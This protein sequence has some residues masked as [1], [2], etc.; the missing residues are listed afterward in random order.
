M[1]LFASSLSS[2]FCQRRR[3][4]FFFIIYSIIDSDTTIGAGSVVGRT[5]SAD[6]QITVVGS[7]LNIMPG[8]DIPGGTMVN[9]AWLQ[10]NKLLKE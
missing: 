6:E 8:A 5:R 3:A 1:L 10:E 7:D 4:S 9:R 2:E